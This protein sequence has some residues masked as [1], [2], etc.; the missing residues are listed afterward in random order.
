MAREVLSA[1]EPTLDGVEFGLIVETADEREVGQGYIEDGRFHLQTSSS[2]GDTLSSDVS[3][4][5]LQ[6][7]LL[8]ALGPRPAPAAH[9]PVLIG[10]ALSDASRATLLDTVSAADRDGTPIAHPEVMVWTAWA[11]W[12]ETDGVGMRAMGVADAG[13]GG[14]ALIENGPDGVVIRPCTSREVWLRLTE[15]LPFGFELAGAEDVPANFASDGSFD[16]SGGRR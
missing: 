11:A 6:L 1:V 16:E 13:D 15:L 3:A 7:A 5:P 4:V 8:V 2:G 9:A 14:I 10:P 12:P